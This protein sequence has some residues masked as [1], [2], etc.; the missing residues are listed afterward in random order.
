MNYADLKTLIANTPACAGKSP[1][2]IAVILASIE[3]NTRVE[4][5]ATERTIISAFAN[6]MDGETF[7]GKL[8]VA[9]QSNPLIARALRWIEPGQ[10]GIDV[11]HPHTAMLLGALLAQNVITQAEHDTVLSIAPKVKPA[12]NVTA[13]EVW[14]AMNWTGE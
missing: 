2:E 13:I 4:T 9:G 1:E 3:G 6:P 12:A 11:S 5:W 14:N 8:A 7:L 10:Q